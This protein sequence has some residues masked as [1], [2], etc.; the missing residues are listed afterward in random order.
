MFCSGGLPRHAPGKAFCKGGLIISEEA[1]LIFCL[2]DD[3]VDDGRPADEFKVQRGPNGRATGGQ[4]GSRKGAP[5]DRP[6]MLTKLRK[7]DEAP[8][9]TSTIPTPPGNR[10]A[11]HHWAPGIMPYHSYG[12]RVW[13][14]LRGSRREPEG[15]AR[16]NSAF[17]EAKIVKGGRSPNGLPC[18]PYTAWK[19]A[20]SI[21]LGTWRPILRHGCGGRVGA[22]ARCAKAEIGFRWLSLQA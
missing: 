20:P 2:D 3:D 17:D 5:R 13:G 22:K 21:P 8:K 6:L 12:G 7:A 9:A 1:S 14:Q 18:D 11:T 15:A 4:R 19:L 10:D 16:T